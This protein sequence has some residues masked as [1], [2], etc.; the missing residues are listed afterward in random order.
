MHLIRQIVLC[1]LL[2]CALAAC[3]Q[4]PALHKFSGAAQG[5]TYSLT[6]WSE[7]AIE[8]SAGHRHAGL[9]LPGHGNTADT[10]EHGEK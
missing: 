5:T 1:A 8:Q 2:L 3:D 7:T 4:A 6:Y 9:H 10:S